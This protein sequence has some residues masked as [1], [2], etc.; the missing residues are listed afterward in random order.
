MMGSSTAHFPVGVFDDHPPVDY[1]HLAHPVEI[2]ATLVF[3][4]AQHESLV[5]EALRAEK[6]D[7]E[8]DCVDA[9]RPGPTG[10]FARACIARIP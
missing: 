6:S 2:E 8:G 3:Q 7:G 4:L 9:V 5:V 1:V 10:P